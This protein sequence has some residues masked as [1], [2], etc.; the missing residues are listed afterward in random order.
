MLRKHFRHLPYYTDLLELFHDVSNYDLTPQTD[1]FI[2]AMQLNLVCLKLNAQ[3]HDI[4]KSVQ[5]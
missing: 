2:D 1:L 5:S 4:V 3:M